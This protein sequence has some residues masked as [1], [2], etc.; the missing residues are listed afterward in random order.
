LIDFLAFDYVITHVRDNKIILVF[1]LR[2]AV[3]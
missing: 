2:F 1:V 3:D